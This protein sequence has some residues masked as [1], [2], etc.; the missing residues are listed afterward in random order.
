MN[1]LAGLLMIVLV[2]CFVAYKFQAAESDR[3]QRVMAFGDSLT[4]GKGDKHG[5][6][7][8]QGLEDELN[9]SESEQKVSFWNYG[10]K[11][12]ETDG[13]IKQLEDYRI[14]TKLDKADTFIVYIGTNDF[15]NSNG[16]D[17]KGINDHKIDGGKREYIRHLERI[18][19]T[20][21]KENGKADILVVGLYNPI[22]GNGRIEKHIQD[23][24]QSIEAVVSKDK[25]MVFIPTDDLFKRKKKAEYFSDS[26]HP[27]E[28]GYKLIT[29][30]ILA[31]YDFK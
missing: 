2:I 18:T 17:L 11:G 1:K 30:R 8:V 10:I 24:N 28:R 25:R 9:N 12:Q 15:I 6:G 27:N 7:Y 13:V 4:Y 19:S 3:V 21:L 22:V 14:H 23:Y 16:G 20:L 31:S 5:Q 26:I 29:N